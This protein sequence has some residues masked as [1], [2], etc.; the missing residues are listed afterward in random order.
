MENM[1]NIN[2]TSNL[3]GIKIR[4]VREWIRKGKLKA[5]KY[6]ESNRWYIPESEIR[7]VKGEA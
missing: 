1:Y 6:E 4:T 2:Q 7:R 5:I 3:L